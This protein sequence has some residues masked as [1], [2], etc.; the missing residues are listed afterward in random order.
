MPW[1]R[2][3][4]DAATYPKLL[5][6]AGLPGA[7][8]RAV[9]EVRG[10]LF[11]LATQSGG[12]TTDYRVDYG[13]AALFG[14]NRTRKLIAWCCT[15]GLLTP[16]PV[17][18]DGVEQWDIINDPNF[19]HIRTKAEL[20]WERQRAA[21]NGNLSLIVPVRLR[22]GDNCRYCGL[23]VQ[24]RGRKSA[25]SA[26]YDHRIAGQRARTPDDLVVACRSCNGARQDNPEWDVNHPIRPAPTHPRYSELSATFLTNNG[27]PTRPNLEPDA[28]AGSSADTAPHP[29]RPAAHPP[30]RGASTTAETGAR[31]RSEKA[32]ET[33]RNSTFQSDPG[34]GETGLTGSGRDGSGPVRPG[35]GQTG[36]GPGGARRRG[37]RGKR[38]AHPGGV[39]ASVSEGGIEG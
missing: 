16:V 30:A 2:F 5:M 32:A 33:P 38:G 27:H 8:G 14:G 24:W 28:T 13:T 37:R 23:Q 18:P 10:W 29:V 34:S 25:R 19:I 20:E 1:V 35:T 6:I 22:D 15:T 7:D 31:T 12:H 36:P 11:A 21:D 17:G 26:E 3:G 39:P 4:D 9:N